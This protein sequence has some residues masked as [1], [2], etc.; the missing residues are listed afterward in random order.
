[1][2]RGLSHRGLGPRGLHSQVGCPRR[3]R[4]RPVLWTAG[5]GTA[6]A[7]GSRR[8]ALSPGE[9]GGRARVERAASGQDQEAGRKRQSPDRGRRGPGEDPWGAEAERRPGPWLAQRAG[10]RRL[11]PERGARGGDLSGCGDR[12]SAPEGPRGALGSTR[13]L[14][15]SAVDGPRPQG[16]AQGPPGTGLLGHPGRGRRA[17]FS[18]R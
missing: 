2:E 8:R 13:D 9:S 11:C 12:V 14:R 10:S 17:G 3:R 16:A 4:T 1:M 15:P 5:P 6:P 7:S 18:G